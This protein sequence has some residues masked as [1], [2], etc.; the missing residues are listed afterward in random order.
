MYA[1]MSPIHAACAL[2]PIDQ[3]RTNPVDQTVTGRKKIVIIIIIIFYCGHRH[4]PG[5]NHKNIILNAL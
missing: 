5:I 2:G 1:K 3:N 4:V